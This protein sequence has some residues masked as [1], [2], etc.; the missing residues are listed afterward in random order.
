M[1]KTTQCLCLQL[2]NKVRESPGFLQSARQAVAAY[3]N[4]MRVA[5]GAIRALLTSD[6]LEPGGKLAW[7]SRPD[8]EMV[9][10]CTP[11]P[12]PD[13]ITKLSYLAE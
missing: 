2:L 11:C 1:Q 5:E 4:Q 9:S 10:S 8:V 6:R 7:N 13:I 12:P 3:E